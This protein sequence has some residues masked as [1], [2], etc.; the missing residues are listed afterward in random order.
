MP[1][2]PSRHRTHVP[3][4]FANR[5]AAELAEL[6][7]TV[8]LATGRPW[9]PRR[10]GSIHQRLCRLHATY[11]AVAVAHALTLA[12]ADHEARNR[13]RPTPGWLV[14]LAL[15]LLEEGPA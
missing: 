8:G 11:G 6:E 14:I 5:A 13:C 15:R 2:R 4:A 10:S 12:G 1:T 7:A 3:P 9:R